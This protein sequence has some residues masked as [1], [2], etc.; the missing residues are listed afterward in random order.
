MSSTR[1]GAPG[2]TTG[3]VVVGSIIW[4][5]DDSSAGRPGYLMR[6]T[7][8]SP[9]LK[10]VAQVGTYASGLAATRDRVWV[11]NGTGDP[12]DHAYKDSTVDEFD[13]SAH[14]LHEYRLV[15]AVSVAARGL[16]AWVNVPQ[17]SPKATPGFPGF[18]S[19]TIDELSGGHIRSLTT[20]WWTVIAQAPMLGVLS[21]GQLATVTSGL[22]DSTKVW[23]IDSNTGRHI[24][25]T[26]VNLS[27]LPS[28][29]IDGTDVLISVTSVATGGIAM[30]TPTTARVLV[31]CG[32]PTSVAA[33]TLGAWTLST[34]DSGAPAVARISETG[35]GPRTTL[36]GAGGTA[37]VTA[38]GT[39]AW[40]LSLTSLSRV[41]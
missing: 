11:V 24:A 9:H 12:R 2:G 13:T 17:G 22:G 30:V 40:V 26:S 14:L 3:L 28:L 32:N 39:S 10:R 37:Q 20:I 7:T 18:G 6:A 21:N 4:A 35:C 25:T 16:K 1:P 38:D 5:L 23:F 36:S 34:K 41:R 31:R 29:T 19:T 27:G 8:T 15:G 33:S